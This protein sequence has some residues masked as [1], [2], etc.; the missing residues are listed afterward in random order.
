[1]ENNNNQEANG[2]S[3]NNNDSDLYANPFSDNKEKEDE[4]D[5]QNQ[6]KENG[7]N[8]NIDNAEENKKNVEDNKKLEEEKDIK[9]EMNEVTQN[10]KNININKNND[11]PQ[12]NNINN[13]IQSLDNNFPKNE[14]KKITEKRP[15]YFTIKETES[16]IYIENTKKLCKMGIEKSLNKLYVVKDFEEMLNL[17]IIKSYS[18]DAILGIID[19]NGN[20][21]YIL[22]ATSSNLIANIIG[23]DIYNILD[24]DLIKITIFDESE[25]E[26]NRKNGIKKLF[27]SKN[28]YYSNTIDLCQ[29]LFIKNRKN[30][31]NDF[32]VNSSLLKIFFDNYI[33]SEF[34]TKII[35][36]Y[37]GFKK[38]I[39]IKNEKN[40]ILVDNLIIERINKHLKF[41]TDIANHMKQIEFICLYKRPNMNAL[42]KNKYNI[43][44]FTFLFYVS[45]EI[46]NHKIQF[47]PWNN[48][49]I[50]ELFQFPNIVCIVHNNVNMNLNNNININNN[51]IKNIIF[52]S[53][54]FGQKIKLLN[55][56]SDWKKNLF[57]DSNNNSN[58]FIKSGS[59]N[60]NHIQEY[61]FWF[62]DINNQYN[63]NDYCFNTIIRLMWKS[64]QQQ[65]NYMNLDINIGQFNK[66]NNEI[67]CNKFKELIMNYHN[68]LD[69]NKKPIYKSQ[70]RKQ[71][72]KVFDYYFNNQNRI[73]NASINI[74][75]NKYNN[76][77]QKKNQINN[78]NND[79]NFNNNNLYAYQNI[80]VNQ[81]KNND[82]ANPFLHN[83]N[84]PMNNNNIN[85]KHKTQT[86]SNNRNNSN[87]MNINQNMSK[88]TIPQKLNI[89]CITWNVGGIS[90]DNNY[91]L[92]D[93][94]TQNIFF[95]NNKVPDII[96]IGLQEIV[97]L[98][99]YNI[100]SITSNEESVSQ[101][102]QL[103]KSTINFIYPNTFKQI[104]IQNL[105]GMYYLCLAQTYLKDKIE[106]IDTKVVKTGL[107]GTLGNKGYLTLNIRIFKNTEISFAVGHLESGSNSNEQRISTLKQILS[108][109][110]GEQEW[111]EQNNGKMFKNS[112][113]WFI[114]GDLNFRI[115][116]SFE[117]SFELIQRREYEKLIEYDQ[118]NYCRL[119]DGGLIE[120][121]E[122]KINFAPTYKYDTNSNNYLN[123]IENLRT[124]S[125]TDRIL[126]CQ[127]N[128]I[129]NLDYSS[130]PSIMYSDHR[131]VEA[132]F[133]VDI[134]Q[135]LK[136]NNTINLF[137]NNNIR[138]NY[139]NNEFHQNFGNNINGNTYRGNNINNYNMNNPNNYGG[140]NNNNFFVNNFKNII[141][142]N[143]NN[144]DNYFNGNINNNNFNNF[145]NHNNVNYPN[146]INNKG[147][148]FNFNNNNIQNNG[149][150]Q[151]S[152]NTK[153]NHQMKHNNNAVFNQR[154]NSMEK[155]KNHQNNFD[156]ITK[157]K[158]IA[159]F[160]K[161]EIN[162]DNNEGKN[163]KNNNDDDNIEN[164]MKF[165]K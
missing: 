121:N 60:P 140:N 114:L 44:I 68:D 52:N 129:R 17:N 50:N 31:I 32:F 88:P 59:I 125:Y 89:L 109:K 70:M 92:R 55:F 22:V 83:N 1:M 124:P 65:I 101:W 123:D 95:K 64:M 155:N 14:E 143:Y 29:N 164:I 141:N 48:F 51:S 79:S 23:A 56:T 90:S 61:I 105:V 10:L 112:D 58:D 13:N 115:G 165:F 134:K 119:R 71:L 91:D 120:I 54:Q 127:R 110:I 2:Q 99:I 16:I 20:N 49:I 28:F 116:T 78:L 63:E 128:N 157:N 53:N 73:N 97:E 67:I 148:S 3:T 25:N 27:Q 36:G 74:Y 75:E 43:N 85:L 138:S 47:N 131:P 118:L 76:N 126:F 96:I 62:I 130:I 81:N 4:N 93:L 9:N 57:F 153:S 135:N 152:N 26:R 35:Y 15:K 139:N 6:R 39:E 100:L 104:S 42:N 162:T 117:K 84:Y 82:F 18:V 108:T 46:A 145:N 40:N 87:M 45:N 72:Q 132:S 66:N 5:N 24:V 150:N 98:D 107:F 149:N 122:A 113:Y 156:N 34:Y 41:N 69:F 158:T 151:F 106:I 160:D 103:I 37:V 94:F 159:F 111:G 137:N 146:I 163:N 19:I 80:N 136:V 33:P 102:T 38:N 12:K 144:K 154:T 86:S 147:N 77:N 142:N 133:E 8:I 11:E 30:I 161:K 21:K 7:I